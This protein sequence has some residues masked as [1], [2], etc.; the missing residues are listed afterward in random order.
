MTVNLKTV[1]ISYLIETENRTRQKEQSKIMKMV[2]FSYALLKQ[3][4]INNL[5]FSHS[6]VT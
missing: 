3:T 2:S 4:G 5:D 6:V 1:I